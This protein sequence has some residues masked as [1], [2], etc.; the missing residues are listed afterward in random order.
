MC[1]SV[2]ARE[3]GGEVLNDL[4]PHVAY[5]ALYRSFA[6]VHVHVRARVSSRSLPLL[7]ALAHAHAQQKQKT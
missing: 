4:E 1:V 7:L 2:R 3:K 6:H 5:F